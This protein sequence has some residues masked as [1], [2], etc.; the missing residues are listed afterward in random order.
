[1]IGCYEH[2]NKQ[3]VSIKGAAYRLLIFQ[4]ELLSIELLWENKGVLNRSHKAY[5]PK[6]LVTQ[7]MRC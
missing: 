6:T 4:D 5:F 1:V 2:C 7:I 3:S